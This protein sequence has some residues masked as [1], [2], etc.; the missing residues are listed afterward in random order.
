MSVDDKYKK[1]FENNSSDEDRLFVEVPT[2]SESPYQEK[3]PSPYDPMGWINLEGRMARGFAGG[4]MPWWVLISGWILF[5]A[6]ASIVL[7]I[8]FSSPSF[9]A[10][11]ILIILAIFLVILWRGTHA[12]LSMKKRR[13]RRR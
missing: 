10:L 3:I 7:A 5:S 2:K 1:Y 4:N 6:Y 9:T 8:V 11:P 13:G 12:K